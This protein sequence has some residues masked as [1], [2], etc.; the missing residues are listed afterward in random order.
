[1]N[2]SFLTKAFSKEGLSVL[3]DILS[4]VGFVIQLIVLILVRKIVRYYVFKGR[5][6]DLLNRLDSH[7][8]KVVSLHQRFE[9]SREQIL[10]ELKSSEVTLKSIKQKAGSPIKQS[11]KRV[12]KLISTYNS[13]IPSHQNKD[14]LFS[15]YAEMRGLVDEIENHR[16]DTDWEK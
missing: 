15:I 5:I 6:P 7:A 12:L 10:L 13:R 3:A 11:A 16:K 2:N 8:S 14:S 9:D 4:V 1:M